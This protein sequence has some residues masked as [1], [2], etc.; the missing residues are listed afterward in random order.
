MQVCNQPVSIMMYSVMIRSSG[1]A[2]PSFLQ[3]LNYM[4]EGTL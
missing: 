1:I 3:L 4:K 2:L